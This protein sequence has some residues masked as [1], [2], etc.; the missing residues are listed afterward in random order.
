MQ[1]GLGKLGKHFGI[2]PKAVESKLRKDLNDKTDP[3]HVY[4]TNQDQQQKQQQNSEGGGN[5]VPNPLGSL[6]GGGLGGLFGGGDMGGGIFS[7]L[8]GGSGGLTPSVTSSM[9]FGNIVG[10][11]GDAMGGMGSLMGGGA[12]AMGGMSSL[13]GGGSDAAMGGMSALAGAFANGGD[14]DPGF[15]FVGERGTELAHFNGGGA[16]MSHDE[17]MSMFGGGDTHIHYH[18]IDAR[19]SQ[20]GVENRIDQVMKS[21]ATHTVKKSVQATNE[22]AKRSPQRRGK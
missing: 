22:R 16:V 3:V 13:I 7:M 20:L 2:T 15:A 6:K 18:S 8:G 17:M 10:E 5:A 21:Y 11:G 14:V 19:G 4:V 12:D 1:E 9:S